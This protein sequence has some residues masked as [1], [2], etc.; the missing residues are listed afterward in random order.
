MHEL[1]THAALSAGTVG[2]LLGIVQSSPPMRFFLSCLILL[3]F[4]LGGCGAQ[5]DLAPD[6]SGL[7]RTD[8][9]AGPDVSTD[10]ARVM[11]PNVNLGAPDS[12]VLC[13]PGQICGNSGGVPG[14]SCCYPM[15]N[16]PGFCPG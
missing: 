15:A 10:A 7:D 2:V 9:D 13:A 6:D 8:A 11:C 12:A 16:Q 5:S 3:A 14:N 4:E 1:L